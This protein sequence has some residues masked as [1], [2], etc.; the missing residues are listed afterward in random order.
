MN[1]PAE[2]AADATAQDPLDLELTLDIEAL[3]L[4]EQNLQ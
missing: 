4:N 3:S 1:P 2:Q